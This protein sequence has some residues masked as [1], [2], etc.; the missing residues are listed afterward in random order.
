MV[1]GFTYFK[2]IIRFFLMCMIFILFNFSLAYSAGSSSS[3]EKKETSIYPPA[4][5]KAVKLVRAEKFSDAL[6]I[7]EKLTIKKPKNADIYNYLG[8]SLRKLNRLD[9]SAHHY[10]QAL[11][12]NP[13]HLG[14]LEYQG[15]LFL[16]LGDVESAKSNLQRI[17]DICRTECEELIELKQAIENFS[18]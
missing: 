3:D 6:V 8:F 17:D 14:A 2:N 18:Q 9:E 4:Y 1:L 16:A 5:Y 10:Q 12:F 11:L 13:K 15:E 7:L